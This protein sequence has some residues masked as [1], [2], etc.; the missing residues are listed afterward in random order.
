VTGREHEARGHDRLDVAVAHPLVLEAQEISDPV[1][2]G[3][4]VAIVAV[5]KH[6]SK[7]TIIASRSRW[8]E[9][10]MPRFGPKPSRAEIARGMYV[11]GELEVDDFERAL[12]AD[13]G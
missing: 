6:G 4:D 12:E 3:D 5:D 7:V 11:R 9:T 13:R 1:R 2:S 10:L 8:N